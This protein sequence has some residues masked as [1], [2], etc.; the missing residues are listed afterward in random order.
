M[1]SIK[2]ILVNKKNKKQQQPEA[3]FELPKYSKLVNN[4]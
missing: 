2:F 1:Q 3:A 4:S